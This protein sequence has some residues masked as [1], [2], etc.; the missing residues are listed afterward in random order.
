MKLK[1]WD[2][3]L[4]FDK[5]LLAI[6]RLDQGFSEAQSRN[7][8]DKLKNSSGLLEIAYLIQNITGTELDTVDFKNQML[9]KLYDSIY[10]KGRQA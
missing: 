6:R 1:V 7:L 3:P 10:Q 4:T 9:K 5:F 8:F 2:E